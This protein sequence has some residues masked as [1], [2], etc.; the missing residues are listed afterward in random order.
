MR[1]YFPTLGLMVEFISAIVVQNF[2][3]LINLF[4]RVI[5]GS[6]ESF[7]RVATFMIMHWPKANYKNINS[8]MF[9]GKFSSIYRTIYLLSEKFLSFLHTV[10]VMLEPG[11]G[12]PDFGRS[13]VLFGSSSSSKFVQ[14]ARHGFLQTMF[15][16]K[17][18][19]YLYPDFTW[20][21]W[22]VDWHVWAS[23]M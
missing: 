20:R 9:I 14:I 17:I 16:Q 12:L 3:N 23:A 8:A 15:W 6:F 22:D 18:F 19:K 5:M 10:A 1:K 21:L 4:S 13:V 2:N 11:E 7:N